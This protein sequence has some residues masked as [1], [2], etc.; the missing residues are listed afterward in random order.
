V[1]ITLE[2][3][4]AA[5][6]VLGDAV[7]KDTIRVALEA[8]LSAAPTPKGVRPTPVLTSRIVKH[9]EYRPGRRSRF[10]RLSC[11]R[12]SPGRGDEHPLS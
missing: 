11:G 10:R 12:A 3:I 1:K 5:R 8:A 6:R 4:K 9:H 2:M 7:P